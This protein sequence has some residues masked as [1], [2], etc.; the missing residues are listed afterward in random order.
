[1]FLQDIWPKLRTPE[2]N[3]IVYK[4]MQVQHEEMTRHFEQGYAVVHTL[5][6]QVVEAACDD[7][8]AFLLPR[9]VYPLVRERLEAK[10]AA[11][12]V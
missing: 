7:P 10:V 12:N 3:E 4:A 1:M 2:L 6:K 9:L 11:H 8:A 5:M